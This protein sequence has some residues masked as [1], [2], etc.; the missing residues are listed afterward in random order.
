MCAQSDYIANHKKGT[1]QLSFIRAFSEAKHRMV[2]S[3][4]QLRGRFFKI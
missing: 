3:E 4:D 1:V 2:L